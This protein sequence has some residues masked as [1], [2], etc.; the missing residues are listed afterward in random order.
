M[1]KY[2][3]CLNIY[4]IYIR[5]ADGSHHA[6]QITGLRTKLMNGRQHKEQDKYF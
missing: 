1:D 3:W 6:L 4:A 2:D 5:L